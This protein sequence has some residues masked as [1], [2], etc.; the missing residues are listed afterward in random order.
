MEQ[1]VTV[2]LPRSGSESRPRSGSAVLWDAL[3]AAGRDL[4]GATR[5]VVLRGEGGVFVDDA[6]ADDSS[7]EAPR[8]AIEWLA[9][10]DMI[11]IASLSGCV[12]GAV[13]DVALSCDL[14]IVADDAQL[15]ASRSVGGVAWLGELMGYSRALEFAVGDAAISGRKAAAMGLANLSVPPDMLDAAVAEM[16][17]AVLR[18]PREVATVAKAVLIESAADTRRKAS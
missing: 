17:A 14:R 3:T 11:T 8:A 6:A 7:D 1:V 9:R 4:T 12:S 16:V 5:V 10:P 15:S 13:L 2:S 18:T